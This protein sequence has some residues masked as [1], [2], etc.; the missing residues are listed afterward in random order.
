V[1][2]GVFA[3]SLEARGKRSS[4]PSII[5]SDTEKGQSVTGKDANLELSAYLETRYKSDDK[6]DCVYN[7]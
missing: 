1:L 6:K 2:A 7:F 5:K 3:F 4:T